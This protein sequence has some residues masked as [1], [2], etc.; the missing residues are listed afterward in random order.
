MKPILL[1]TASDGARLRV[2]GDSVRVLAT[3]E[4]TGKNFEVFDVNGPR[5]S[6][7]PPHAHPW[8]EAYLVVA[9]TMEVLVGDRPEDLGAGGFVFIPAGVTHAYRITSEHA[10]FVV[11]T[12]P[13]R[14][15]DLFADLDRNAGEDLPKIVEV[16]ISHG[17]T[18]PA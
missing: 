6:G 7:P 2:V 12:G 9:G 3:T 14:A 4:Q 15:S 1:P 5:E 11:I 13:G 18:L 8:A 10:S 17:L 16:A